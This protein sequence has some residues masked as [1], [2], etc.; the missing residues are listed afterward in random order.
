[1]EALANPERA[2]SLH[3]FFK[4]GSGQYG[5]GDRFL[6]IQVPVQRRLVYRYVTLSLPEVT[7]LLASPIHEHRFTGIEILV[8][9]YER[10]TGERADKLFDFST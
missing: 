2:E 5:E 9:Q 3:W 1:M 7:H 6:G 4:A 10:A 8:A